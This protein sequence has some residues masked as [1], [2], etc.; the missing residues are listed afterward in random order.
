[1]YLSM[2][3]AIA[4]PWLGNF[5]RGAASGDTRKIVDSAIFSAH[6]RASLLLRPHG[7]PGDSGSACRTAFDLSS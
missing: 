3:I 6:L 2:F 7:Y 5:A 4:R 1:M